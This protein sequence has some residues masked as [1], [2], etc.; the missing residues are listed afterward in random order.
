MSPSEKTL[1]ADS[2]TGA[3]VIQWT[4]GPSNNQ[5]LYFTSPSATSDDR[6][7]VFLSDRSGH[8][9]L[10]VIDRTTGEIS[11]VSENRS[12]LRKSYVYPRGGP[13]GLS[14]SSPSLD[15]ERARLCYV[16][17][18]C[19]CAVELNAANRQ[20]RRIAE[21][22][23][24]WCGAFTHISPDG[25]TLCVPCT[26]GAAFVDSANTQWEQMRLVPGRMERENLKTRLYLIDIETGAVRIAA[27]LDFWVTHVQFDPAGSGRIVFNRE[28]FA[29]ESGVPPL[30]RI[31]C[32]ETNG[33]C[34]PLSPEPE[35]EWRSHENWAPD[36]SGII[37]HGGRDG[38]TFVAVRAWGGSL[39]RESPGGELS[40]YHATG[41]PGG[42]LL[43]DRPDG[44]ISLIDPWDDP[45]RIR[46]ICRHDTSIENQDA[47]AHPIATAR[48]KSAIFTSNRSG[49][50][51]VYEVIADLGSLDLD[52]NIKNAV[53]E[54]LV[55]A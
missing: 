11:M 3:T 28:G 17:D 55:I 41:V 20:V 51:Q 15:P 31:W 12:G 44:F 47:H 33:A 32:M 13:G 30:N 48:G 45:V 6:W 50:C 46:N 8:P 10:H 53:G 25:R 23:P 42:R 7:L 9:N 19:V 18:D 37:Y 34:R 39:L 4:A 49:C 1:H 16:Q 24:G 35:G 29:G 40:V 22:P 43:A 21:L 36:G 52:E 2:A 54:P 14:K 38:R 27:E 26:D 5:H